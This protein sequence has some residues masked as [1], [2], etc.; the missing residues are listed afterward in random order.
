MSE[1][2]VNNK[3]VVLIGGGTGNSVLL[4]TLKR[5]TPNIT[6]IVTVGDDGGSSGILRREL[7]VIP[8]GDI[9]NC[10]VALADEESVMASVMNR[11][12]TKGSLKKQNLGNIILTALYEMSGSF[13][14]AIKQISEVLAISGVV[15]PV[16]CENI[17]LCAR[18]N[19][20]KSIKGESKIALYASRH[21]LEISQIQLIPQNPPLFEDC[22]LAIN[23]ADIIIF[24]PGS[25]YTS[26]IPNL[27]VD[28]MLKA[29]KDTK[30]KRY[31]LANIMTEYGETTDYSLSD[32]IAAIEKHTDNNKVFDE[33][34]YNDSSLPRD[35]LERYMRE[36]QYPV[37]ADITS[38][39]KRSYSFKGMDIADITQN[40]LRHNAKRIF[41]YIFKA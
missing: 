14:M 3:K 9:R 25:L 36:N 16:T 27:L 31:Y 4:K 20:G 39:H 35:V 7:G 21:S 33:V 8:P 5:Y 23:E 26:L 38:K 1:S 37:K 30:A 24:S 11:R 19:N 40:G 34:I 29:L 22:A 2:Y 10:L 13:P 15:L 18:Y 32:H 6:V 28:G 41:E 17:Q 12:F